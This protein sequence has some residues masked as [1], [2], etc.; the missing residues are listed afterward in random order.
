MEPLMSQTLEI[1]QILERLFRKLGYD[2][3]VREQQAMFL[4][5]EIVGEHVARNSQPTQIDNG[6]MSVVV[7]DSVWLTELNLLRMQYIAKINEQLGAKVVR[8]I[9]FKIGRVN[10]PSERISPRRIEAE[11]DYRTKLEEIELDPEELKII[12]QAVAKV[13]DE[14]LGEILKRIFTDQK[15][16]AKLS[17]LNAE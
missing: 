16:S 15:K 12:G 10:R 4:W 8:E 7:S 1:G 14:E 17:K 5:D 3:K 2:K 6:R 11:E 13:E 9:D